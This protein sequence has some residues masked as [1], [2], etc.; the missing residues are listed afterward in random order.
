MAKT[1]AVAEFNGQPMVLRGGELMGKTIAHIDG[2]F[3][4]MNCC[5]TCGIVRP[6]DGWEKPCKGPTSL[7]PSPFPCTKCERTF[8]TQ[9]ALNGHQRSHSFFAFLGKSMPKE[10]REKEHQDAKDKIMIAAI[11]HRS[12]ENNDEHCDVCAAVAEVVDKPLLRDLMAYFES[13]KS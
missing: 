4:G 3:D 2:E 10:F 8:D 1:E 13:E 6:H 11:H 12:R 5:L 7:R 9:G